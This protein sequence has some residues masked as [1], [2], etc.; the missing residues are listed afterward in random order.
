[1]TEPSYLM[2][3]NRPGLAYIHS[4]AT[5]DGANAPLVMFLGGFMSDMHGTKATFLETQCRARGQEFLRFDYSGHGLSDG[6]FVD[7]TIGL[8]KDDALAVFDHVIKNPAVLVG[9]SMGGWIALHLALSRPERVKAIVGI[10][11]APDF[12]QGMYEEYLTDA[13]KREITERGFTEMPSDYGAPYI[14]TRALIE[15]GERQLLLDRD[16]DLA[17]PIRLLQGKEDV[18]VPW[19]TALII[20][21]RFKAADVEITLIEDGDHSLSRPEDLALIDQQV[22]ALSA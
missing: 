9:S 10:A 15:D 7:G 22:Q 13:Q 12:T 18:Q 8:W 21:E 4:P 16:H 6:K 2:R 17:L 1:M 19:Q 11:A 20:K 14:I 3:K 5:P